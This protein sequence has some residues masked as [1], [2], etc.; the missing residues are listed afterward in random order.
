MEKAC[1]TVK[2]M[3][4]WKA[5]KTV[6]LYFRVSMLLLLNTQFCTEFQASALEFEFLVSVLQDCDIYKQDTISKLQIVTDTGG[7]LTF[8]YP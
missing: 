7:F 5:A 8:V 6:L 4:Q 2:R 1:V 3:S